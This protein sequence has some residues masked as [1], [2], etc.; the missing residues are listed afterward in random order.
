MR[1]SITSTLASIAAALTIAALIAIAINPASAQT[2]NDIDAPTLCTRAESIA[3]WDG[4]GAP[5][6]RPSVN[7]TPGRYRLTAN[8]PDADSFEI[9]LHSSTLE[10][11][12]SSGYVRTHRESEYS[13]EIGFVVTDENSGNYHIKHKYITWRARQWSIEI[14]RITVSA[15]NCT[16]KS[17][18]WV[19]TGDRT[20]AFRDAAILDPG[21]YTTV[22]PVGPSSLGSWPISSIS[23]AK[24]PTNTHDLSRF[25]IPRLV[26][27]NE[28]AGVWLLHVYVTYPL[29]E[30]RTE[31]YPTACPATPTPAVRKPDKPTPNDTET[32]G[33]V[34]LTYQTDSAKTRIG[35][36]N[37]NEVQA[38]QAAGDWLTAFVYTDQ[39]GEAYTIKRLEPGTMHAFIVGA[40]RQN[41]TT[42][43]SEWQFHT[44][45]AATTC[46]CPAAA[47]TPTAT[48]VP[49][50]TATPAPTPAPTSSSTQE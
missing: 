30:W 24:Q 4:N 10:K 19:V 46:A 9:Q 36:A 13:G 1:I 48:S 45:Q 38:A 47:P 49:T 43:W 6:V 29:R 23:P 34:R 14:E 42:A 11:S 39:P 21:C 37:I 25:G 33:E 26:V 50:P 41:G 17:A 7:L 35:W 20:R 15:D 16:N 28:T 32:P 18:G 12:H 31:I 44:T 5:T 22:G 8:A 3:R 27:T 40:Y 2:D